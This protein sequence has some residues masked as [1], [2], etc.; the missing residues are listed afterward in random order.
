V[1]A[2]KSAPVWCDLNI[3]GADLDGI[4]DVS[5]DTPASARR[6]YNLKGMPVGGDPDTPGLYIIDGRKV[7]VK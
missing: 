6:C 7:L 4:S 1:A 3:V 2:Y 5:V